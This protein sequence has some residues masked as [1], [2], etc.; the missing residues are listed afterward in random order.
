MFKNI[1]PLFV[2]ALS[3]FSVNGMAQTTRAKKLT[4]CDAAYFGNSTNNVITSNISLQD[5]ESWGGYWDGKE[6]GLSSLGYGEVPMTYDVAISYPKGTA[7]VRGLSVEGMRFSFPS[8]DDIKDVK[9]WM[10]TKLP[11]TPGD[12]DILVQEVTE[13][14]SISNKQDPFI[15]V[16][17]DKPYKYDGSSDLFIGYSFNVTG[18][19][20]EAN[21]SPVLVTT[22]SEDPNALI[23]KFN[24]AEGEW[25]DY[26]G[27]NLGNAAVQVLLKGTLPENEAM[28]TPSIGAFTCKGGTQV[29]IPLTFENAGTNALESMDFEISF[30]GESSKVHLDP[31]YPIEEI[32]G[33]LFYDLYVTAPTDAKAYEVSVK[34]EKV[35]GVES[36]LGAVGRGMVYCVSDVVER[37]P[38]VEEFTAMWCG[39]CPRG[40]VGMEK[41]RKDFGNDISL[42]AVHSDDPIDCSADYKDILSTVVAVPS[43]HVDRFYLG[44]DPFYG[45]GMPYGIKD[46]VNLSKERIPA[47]SVEAYAE[48]NGDILTAKSETKFLFSGDASGFS[49][50]YVLTED[51][52]QNDTWRQ[53]NFY[54]GKT[55]EGLEEEDP[56]FEYWINEGKFVKGVIYN[57]VA[58][59]AKGV[60]EGI[61]GSVPAEVVDGA[62]NTHSVEFDLS[63]YELVQNRDNLNVIALV[64]DKINGNVVNSS[65]VSLG[66]HSAINGVTEDSGAREVARYTIDGRSISKPQSGIN[67]VKYSD[68]TVKKVVVR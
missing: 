4:V 22:M 51:E 29:Y 54:S 7:S 26:Y 66:V 25:Y 39:N 32:G 17:F 28:V 20:T 14:T 3:V 38:L 67:L 52:M 47:A 2:L 11:V 55:G 60:A 64:I 6:A 49:I 59:A 23:L 8:S 33:T 15:E 48:I 56:L 12:A 1:I 57:D 31:S 19:A 61:D 44:V 10:S 42:V 62:A 63:K 24:G 37:I 46:I 30:N 58:I 27:T 43:A 34:I 68:G 16:R 9:V 41:L 35:N 50:G 18:E 13:L 45:Y 40:F 53:S 21:L 36:K 5:E 65:T